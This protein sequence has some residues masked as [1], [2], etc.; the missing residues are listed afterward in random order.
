MPVLDESSSTRRLDGMVLRIFLPLVNGTI[1]VPMGVIP[2]EASHSVA[3]ISLRHGGTDPGTSYS[4]RWTVTTNGR[5]GYFESYTSGWPS[6]SLIPLW[7]N[8]GGGSY[9]ALSAGSVVTVTLSK[10]GSAIDL[11]NVMIE[12]VIVPY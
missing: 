8:G 6:G 7:T 3:S 12:A 11:S 9:N 2:S 5:S 4:N 10:S 1:T